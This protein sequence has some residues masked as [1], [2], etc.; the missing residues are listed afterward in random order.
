MNIATESHH[1]L[2]LD[3]NG[4]LIN[5]NDW[6]EDVALLMAHNLGIEEL[7]PDHWKVIYAFRQHYENFGVAP[8]ISHICHTH[9]HESDWVH[10]LFHSCLNSWRIAGLPDPGE[11]AKA[12][13]S[14][15]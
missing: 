15:M 4:L 6:D 9:G 5:T 7:T 8:T 11:E 12:Y 13:M 14:N 2:A 3:V 1:E 10:Q